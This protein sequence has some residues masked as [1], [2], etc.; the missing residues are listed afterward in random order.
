VLKRNFFTI[1]FIGWMMFVTFSSLFSFGNVK[2][3]KIDIPHLDKAVH[4][5]FYAVACVLGILFL[6]ERSRGK[7]N[8]LKGLFAMV[9]FTVVFGIIIEVLQDTMTASRVLDV[10]DALANTLG[11]LMAG[12]VLWMNKSLHVKN[13]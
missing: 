11:A 2:P 4:F 13:S 12:I 7:M 5:I 9:I 10:Y 3:P 1:A 6:R 8:F